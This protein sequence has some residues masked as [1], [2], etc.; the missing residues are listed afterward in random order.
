[1]DKIFDKYNLL[2]TEVDE[3]DLLSFLI[4][5]DI[6]DNG[7]PTF[8]LDLLSEEIMNVIPEYVFAEYQGTEITKQNAMNLLRTSAKSIYKIKEFDLMGRVY[9]ENDEAAKKELETAP[10]KIEANLASYYCIF[11]LE[12]LEI[13]YLLYQKSIS[14]MRQEFRLMVL[15]RFIFLLTKEYYGLEKANFI[16]MA[17]L[18]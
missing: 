12:T 8:P 18:V 14:K 4:K 7:N 16:P 11:F 10:Y 6:D 5:M 13:Q 2:I 17:N 15:M 1:M 3:K 9:L